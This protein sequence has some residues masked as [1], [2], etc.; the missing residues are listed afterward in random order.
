MA[1]SL[2]LAAAAAAVERRKLDLQRAPDCPS[3]PQSA[4]RSTRRPGKSVPAARRQRGGLLGRHRAARWRPPSL[5]NVAGGGRDKTRARSWFQ[6]RG[7]CRSSAATSRPAEPGRAGSR[8]ACS[9]AKRIMG[10]RCLRVSSTC[11]LGARRQ[12]DAATAKCSR[13]ARTRLRLGPMRGG[14][15]SEFVNFP[16]SVSSPDI[17]GSVRAE[18]LAPIAIATCATVTGA[19][20]TVANATIRRQWPPAPGELLS[21]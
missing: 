16:L 18:R 1:Q 19:T 12:V 8:R 13:S 6:V 17:C 7:A 2:D 15:R 11:P 20:T 14:P 10:V 9:L 4:R 3:D 5:M 21:L